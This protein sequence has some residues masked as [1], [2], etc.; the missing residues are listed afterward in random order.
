MNITAFFN[1]AIFGNPAITAQTPACLV[2]RGIAAAWLHRLAALFLPPSLI[3]S[4]CTA[5]RL[6]CPA[7]AGLSVA[8]LLLSALA[9]PAFAQTLSFNAALQDR[10]LAT[11]GGALN[12]KLPNALPD[13]T[14]TYTLTPALPA[15][16]TFTASTRVLAGNP[17][18]AKA[19]TTYTYTAT[20]ADGDTVS[21]T[22]TIEVL[23]GP[24][25]H[26]RLSGVLTTLQTALDRGGTDQVWIV[27]E[28]LPADYS[29]NPGGG[30]RPLTFSIS[31][32]LPAGMS[33]GNHPLLDYWY[34]FSGTPTEAMPTTTYTLTVTDSASPPVSAD[35]TFTITVEEASVPDFGDAVVD[36][37]IWLTDTALNL[38]LPEVTGGNGTIT[39]SLA[40]T[41]LPAGLS[42]DADTRTLSG[43][44]TTASAAAEYT[45]TATDLDG[46]TDTYTFT[47][48]VQADAAPAFAANAT[49]ADQTWATGNA[50][51]ALVLPEASGGNTTTG[52]AA[53]PL[54]YSLTPDLPAGLTFDPA[55]RTIS[56]TP[57]AAAQGDY[58]WTVTDA[59]NNTATSDAASL[60]FSITVTGAPVAEDATYT[61]TRT[62]GSNTVTIPASV[63]TGAYTD[64][65]NDGLASVTI[66][67]LPTGGTLMIG[68]GTA[69]TAVTA[70]QSL[71]I[72]DGE[73]DDGPLTF[74][75]TAED[76]QSTTLM[77]TLSDGAV[78]SDPATLTITFG[79]NITAEQTTQISAILSATAIT[80]ATTAI[81]GAIAA[82]ATD[83]SLDGTSLA[84]FAQTLHQSNAADSPR[85]AWYLGTA[86]QWEHNAAYN[87][88]D[89]SA[90][91]LLNRLQSM[92]NSDIALNYSLTDTSNMRFW[93][94]YQS[95]DI[96]GNEGES[97]EYD[98]SGT[99]FY[100]GADNQITERLR[101][102]LAIGT[103]SSDITLDLDEDG[104][105]DEAT[106]SATSFYPYLHIDLGNNNNARVIAGFG[107]GTLDIK[108]TANSNSTASA[109]LSWNM[110]AA[111]ISHHRPMKGSLS[112]RFDG[113]LQLGNTST[114]ETT[115]SSGSTLM[116]ADSSASE[117]SINAELR[118]QK[119]N[120]TPFASLAARKLGGDISQSVAL[121]MAFGADLQTSPA[122]LRFAITRQINDTTHQRHSISIDAFTR[123]SASGISASLGS[124]YDSLSGRPQWQSTVRWQ[125][126]AAE[127]S[128]AASQSDYRLQARLR[129]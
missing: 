62:E 85:Q 48:A 7:V 65:D 105:D 98:G 17:T 122:N 70:N 91:S 33:G 67:T 44:P 116:A 114:D 42:F 97:L 22:F 2:A 83:L 104:T 95:L 34:L 9:S 69:A 11:N 87:A 38:T 41:T 113:S 110:L 10:L 31:P 24:T 102:G 12:S 6:R 103:D 27:G 74:T 129:W 54:A 121:D 119:N 35:Y 21:D 32:A 99:G 94:R 79:G 8:I 93:A 126:K 101:I 117:L 50:I 46:D 61:A 28:A 96:N 100:L 66:T 5:V 84:G 47:A 59:D 124:R 37:R 29:V 76:L 19:E 82:P 58:T 18:A 63:F 75:I 90:E 77:F 73:F 43:T 39:Y 71:A 57:T 81:G 127:L 108:S 92:A 118:Y 1:K 111:S 86:P 128:L 25:W 68:E 125:N 115:F 3:Y 51:T 23:Q 15:G 107:S 112:A 40:P 72:T 78:N 26:P 120:I 14:Y 55:T 53:I 16:L 109:D 89:N 88:S 30:V 4:P 64:P 106:R 52:D 80:N 13:G 45:L 60:T 49:I 123:P 20:N 56:D 36:S